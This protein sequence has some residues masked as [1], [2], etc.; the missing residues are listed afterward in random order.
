M[1]S[2]KILRPC[3]AVE[4]IKPSFAVEIAENRSRDTAL[5]YSAIYWKFEIDAHRTYKPPTAC[6]M[7]V[8]VFGIS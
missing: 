6:T 7:R 5:V 4:R 1:L 2:T 8:P 3:A